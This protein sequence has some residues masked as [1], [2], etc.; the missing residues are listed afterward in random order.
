MEYTVI[1]VESDWDDDDPVTKA[2]VTLIS[3]V[4]EYIQ[5]GW[6]PQ[7][8]ICQ[9][10]IPEWVESQFSDESGGHIDHVGLAQAMIRS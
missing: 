2:T 3:K 9:Y 1:T 4:N 5:D 7:G 10:R 8:G 6:R